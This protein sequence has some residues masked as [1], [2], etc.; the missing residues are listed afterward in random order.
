MED[1]FV[2]FI[3]FKSM[4]LILS[5]YLTTTYT[6]QSTHLRVNKIQIEKQFRG[7]HHTVKFWG[8]VVVI[9]VKHLLTSR[10]AALI[11]I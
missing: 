2:D 6:D 3:F 7:I 5:R 9:V 10:G 8:R 1:D 4:H 11:K